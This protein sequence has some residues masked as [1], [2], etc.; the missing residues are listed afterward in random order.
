MITSNDDHALNQPQ[1]DICFLLRLS[2]EVLVEIL[3]RFEWKDVLAI[4]QCSRLLYSVSKERKVW[5]SIL[6]NDLDT[7]IPRPFYLP[8]P[9]AHCSSEDLEKRVVDW[10]LGWGRFGSSAG[11]MDSNTGPVLSD[12]TT[13]VDSNSNTHEKSV[14]SPG[15]DRKATATLNTGACAFDSDEI[16]VLCGPLLPLPTNQYFLY[17][18]LEDGAVYYGDPR[19]P[20]SGVSML[21]PSPFPDLFP[22][23][24]GD[25]DI[26]TSV[27]IDV[28]GGAAGAEGLE[29]D[30]RERDLVL[31]LD[32][33][34]FPTTFRLMVSNYVELDIDHPDVLLAEDNPTPLVIEVWEI[35]SQVADDTGVVTGYSA[36]RLR[37]LMDNKV[38]TPVN[39]ISILGKYVAYSESW[40]PVIT[41]VDWTLADD[42]GPGGKDDDD[43]PKLGRMYVPAKQYSEHLFLLPNKKILTYSTMAGVHVWDWEGT[44]VTATSRYEVVESGVPSIPLWTCPER[45]TDPLHPFAAPFVLRGCTRFIL[46][47]DDHVIG[48]SIQPGSG[49]DG[50]ENARGCRITATNLVD[51]FPP[52]DLDTRGCWFGYSKG[53][54]YQSDD[55]SYECVTYKW[56]RLGDDEEEGDEESHG[57]EE[58]PQPPSVKVSPRHHFAN[59][60]ISHVYYDDLQR[61]FLGLSETE[62]GKPAAG[63]VVMYG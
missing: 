3:K 22:D 36:R 32:E 23:L 12:P 14:G 52:S 58:L 26:V 45:I 55:G 49:G 44:C 59:F 17:S 33:S 31:N 24:D 34:T 20:E 21:V 8:K 11:G 19:R 54:S 28:L 37:R 46:P 48:L 4:R 43:I 16:P 15:P 60:G 47:F 29:V 1:A 7:R 50:E 38:A 42:D 2:R 30:N 13:N 25:E 9:L 5:V 10:Y 62:D 40:N 63:C 53:M 39:G 6:E 27:S 51:R 41:I 18:D 57:D 61:Q 35:S 56:P